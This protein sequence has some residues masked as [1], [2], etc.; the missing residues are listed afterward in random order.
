M[1][2]PPGTIS[3]SEFVLVK[4]AGMDGSTSLDGFALSTSGCD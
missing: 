4:E 1:G 3:D 2:F